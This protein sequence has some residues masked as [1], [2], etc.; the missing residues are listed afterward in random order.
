MNS[1]QGEALFSFGR[2]IA[3]IYAANDFIPEVDCQLST[4]AGP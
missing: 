2:K 1:A 3:M 4:Y